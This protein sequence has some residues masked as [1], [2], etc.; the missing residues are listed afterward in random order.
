MEFC[1]NCCFSQL[2]TY[3]VMLRFQ[4]E[5]LVA[6]FQSKVNFLLSSDVLFY[7][8]KQKERNSNYNCE[9]T[10]KIGLI[11]IAIKVITEDNKGSNQMRNTA[12][13]LLS[14]D[15]CRSVARI[16]MITDFNGI[17]TCLGLFCAKRLG[18]RVHFRFIFIFFLCVFLFCMRIILFCMRIILNLSIWAMDWAVKLKWMLP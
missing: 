6:I 7:C 3:I 8:F 16:V 4:W 2:M 18:N 11:M 9:T 1:Q 15:F 17:S 14:C 12:C 5:H 10:A 13:G